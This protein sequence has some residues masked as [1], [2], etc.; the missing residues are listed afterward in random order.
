LKNT[1][2]NYWEYQKRL[3][4]GSID[5]IRHRTSK[6]DYQLSSIYKRSGSLSNL[7][8]KN[9]NPLKYGRYS[10]C[11][12]NIKKS[13]FITNKERKSTNVTYQ[14]SKYKTK[15]I[16]QR[17][18]SER[19]L[20]NPIP[21]SSSNNRNTNNCYNRGQ[22]LHYITSTRESNQEKLPKQLSTATTTSNLTRSAMNTSSESSV[23]I[24]SK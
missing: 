22:P 9:S 5:H 3:N 2:P 19:Y 14:K 18:Y 8:S 23:L 21:Y 12:F 13:S 20:F 1:H 17:R 7:H 24:W 4:G 6:S 10:V 11:E 15:D 16:Y